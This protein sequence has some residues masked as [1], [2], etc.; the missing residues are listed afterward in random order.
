MSA[1]KEEPDGLG[2]ARLCLVS[3]GYAG[4][5]PQLEELIN[6]NPSQLPPP[7]RRREMRVLVSGMLQYRQHKCPAASESF[8]MLLAPRPP[9]MGR[10]LLSMD[11]TGPPMGAG[12]PS[13]PWGPG[14]VGHHRSLADLVLAMCL[15]R[16]DLPAA[17]D[18]YGD[19][20]THAAPPTWRETGTEMIA[21]DALP[22]YLAF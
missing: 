3:D 16:M 7:P 10:G 19:A 4:G 17:G 5:L 14:S 21:A 1:S 6:E 15:R 2:V 20:V 22:T 12:V 18:R 13:D 11:L 9:P 8:R